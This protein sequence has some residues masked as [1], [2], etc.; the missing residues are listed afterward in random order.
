MSTVKSE[1]RTSVTDVSYFKPNKESDDIVTSVEEWAA[2]L[3]K[4]D[5]TNILKGVKRDSNTKRRFLACK[6]SN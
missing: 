5:I 2:R 6:K 3:L 4:P 1:T